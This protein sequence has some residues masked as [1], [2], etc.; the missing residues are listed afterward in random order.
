MPLAVDSYREPV[1]VG[2]GEADAGVEDV[3]PVRVRPARYDPDFVEIAEEF[4]V[5]ETLDWA[6]QSFYDWGDRERFI[7]KWREH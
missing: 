1:D 6:L 2:E 5:V 4:D 3:D 7:M